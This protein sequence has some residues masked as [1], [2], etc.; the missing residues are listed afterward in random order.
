MYL[1]YLFVLYLQSLI[2]TH[3]QVAAK[4]FETLPSVANNT[5]M[6]SSC[7]M[8][9]DTVRM[10]SIQKKAGEP[11]VRG[12]LYSFQ[13]KCGSELHAVCNLLYCP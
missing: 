12:L 6:S 11:L 4:S 13:S 8:P 3:D 10:I 7:P 5:T 9:V 2:E 1:I